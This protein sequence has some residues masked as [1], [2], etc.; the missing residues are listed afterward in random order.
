[1]YVRPADGA[2][3]DFDQNAALSDRGQRVLFDFQI[4]A[5]CCHHSRFCCF[6]HRLFPFF[7]PLYLRLRVR[8]SGFPAAIRRYL[9]EMISLIESRFHNPMIHPSVARLINCTINNVHHS[10]RIEDGQN[11]DMPFRRG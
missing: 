4:H 11:R 6:S 2:T 8:G 1:M 9:N 5:G 3:G 10:S 7:T